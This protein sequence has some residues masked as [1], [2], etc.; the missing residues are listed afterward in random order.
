MHISFAMLPLS[1]PMS[2][3]TATSE[4]DQNGSF[5]VPGEPERLGTDG[6]FLPKVS[7]ATGVALFRQVS[8]AGVSANRIPGSGLD[9]AELL[10]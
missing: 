8:L 2:T 10:H 7:I 3:G 5:P 4:A 9:F 6:R 1:P